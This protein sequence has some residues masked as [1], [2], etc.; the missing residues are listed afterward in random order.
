MHR[1][2]RTSNAASYTNFVPMVRLLLIFMLSTVSLVCAQDF[3]VRWGTI[4]HRDQ[5]LTVGYGV[6]GVQ[7]AITRNV[8]DDSTLST[9]GPL[10]FAYT[11]DLDSVI[12]VGAEIGYHELTG[13]W[14]SDD[15]NPPSGGRAIPVPYSKRTVHLAVHG[16]WTWYRTRW[17]TLSSTASVGYAIIL[18][19]GNNKPLDGSAPAYHLGVASLR[20]TGDVGFRI[21]VGYGYRGLVNFGMSFVM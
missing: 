4:G 21:E 2:Y 6:G 19:A 11:A 14:L 5:R 3:N 17:V 7:N 13:R 1:R 15:T 12:S 18:H 20:V 16:E 10:W 8:L 9:L